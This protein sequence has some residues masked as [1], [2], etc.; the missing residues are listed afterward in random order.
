[1]EAM[2]QYQVTETDYKTT[3]LRVNVTFDVTLANNT[4]AGSAAFAKEFQNLL[5]NSHEALLAQ[6]QSKPYKVKVQARRNR[7]PKNKTV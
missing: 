4:Q 6:L 1:M 5:K 3:N 2:A 7:K